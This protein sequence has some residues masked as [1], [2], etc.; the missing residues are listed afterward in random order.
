MDSNHRYPSGCPLGRRAITS[1]V[2]DGSDRRKFALGDRRHRA[3]MRPVAVGMQE[4]NGDRLYHRLGQFG[5]LAADLV[6][7]ERTQ[8]HA[9]ARADRLSGGQQQRVAI[10]RVLAQESRVILADEPV[11]SLDPAA[12]V[13][14]LSLLRDIAHD[15]ATK[16]TAPRLPG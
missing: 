15:R 10:A 9:V 2:M 11:A 16:A 14:V 6:W 8:H 3:L 7:I 12:A 5:D 1:I 13:S 4:A